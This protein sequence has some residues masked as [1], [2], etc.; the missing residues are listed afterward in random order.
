[1]IYLRRVVG[2]SMLPLL[3][4]GKLIIFISLAKPKV[5]S[6][7]LAN[8]SARDVVKTITKIEANKYWLEGL[9]RS[10]S[11]DSRDYCWVDRKKILACALLLKK[12]R[13]FN[14]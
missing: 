6:I 7:V 11:T 9:N 5:G 1:V 10:H 12:G 2:D 4:P 14:R 3:K 13:A 8:V